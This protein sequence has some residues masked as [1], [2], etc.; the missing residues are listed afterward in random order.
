VEPDGRN[1]VSVSLGGNKSLLLP[2]DEKES[3]LLAAI[4]G[5]VR[6]GW[7]KLPPQ[8]GQPAGLEQPMQ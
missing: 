7:H 3:S 4:L 6:E 2:S 8:L 5:K 1:P